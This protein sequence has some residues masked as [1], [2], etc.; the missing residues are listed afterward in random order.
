MRNKI[1]TGLLTAAAFIAATPAAATVQVNFTSSGDIANN[2]NFKSPEL[3]GLGLDD[4]T[5]SVTSL[6]LNEDSFIQF[7]FLGSE[8]GFSDNF[9]VGAN[10]LYQENSTGIINQFGAPVMLGG[11]IFYLAGNIT[12]LL[13]GSTNGGTSAM[14]GQSGFGVLLADGTQ[15]GSSTNVFYLAYDDQ[16]TGPDDDN[17][18]D[19]IIRATV[20]SAVPEPGTWAMMLLGFGTVGFAM[21]KR[22]RGVL[23]A[24]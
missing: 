22:A 24:A 10:L 1:L 20:R 6:V 12:D 5:T 18:D 3:S 14:V 4:I 16:I 9:S 7:E 13:F 23:Q 2:N 19:I 17:H 11:E 21:R 8:S 15:S